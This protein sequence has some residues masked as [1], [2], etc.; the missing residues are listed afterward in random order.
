MA[1]IEKFSLY[2][3]IYIICRYHMSY[4]V[5]LIYSQCKNQPVCF[6]S[7]VPHPEAFWWSVSI[8]VWQTWWIQCVSGHFAFRSA[9]CQIALWF[10]VACLLWQSMGWCW[11]SSSISTALRFLCDPSWRHRHDPLGGF[12]FRKAK[13]GRSVE[14][15]QHRLNDA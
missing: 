6:C 9:L 3:Y 13:A 7:W 5:I 4:Y 12:P 15:V 8:D 10:L 11:T 14:H 2:A 1:I